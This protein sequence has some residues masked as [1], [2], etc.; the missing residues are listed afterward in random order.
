MG[1]V[2]L[3]GTSRSQREVAMMP[4]APRIERD[5]S[6]CYCSGHLVHRNGKSVAVSEA[7]QQQLTRAAQVSACIRITI[8]NLA[9]SRMRS[10]SL[11]CSA[12][13]WYSFFSAKARINARRAFVALPV[14]D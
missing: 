10:R 2:M 4:A 8:W 11:S 1:Q 9:S 12:S 3:G 7:P 6:G 5:V 14:S 13:V